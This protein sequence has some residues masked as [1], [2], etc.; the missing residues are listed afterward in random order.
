MVSTLR[1]CVSSLTR[2]IKAYTPGWENCSKQHQ[3][4]CMF[5]TPLCCKCTAHYA[6]N[7]KACIDIAEGYDTKANVKSETDPFTM[8]LT[9][10][11]MS[12]ERR[13]ILSDVGSHSTLKTIPP[14]SLISVPWTAQISMLGFFIAVDTTG[15]AR[16]LSPLRASKWNH[17]M[18]CRIYPPF[19]LP[20]FG[21]QNISAISESNQVGHMF[22]LA[23]ITQN[24][25][26]LLNAC[27]SRDW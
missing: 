20:I 23:Y 17:S 1:A 2:V 14:F 19:T 9:F 13:A 26:P 5:R 11:P 24:T 10:H 25:A 4:K 15:Q 22:Q 21:S 3:T 6:R 27:L 18:F 16:G 7:L 12:L 8:H